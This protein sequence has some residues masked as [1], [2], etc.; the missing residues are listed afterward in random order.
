MAG[1]C[2]QAGKQKRQTNPPPARERTPR[3]KTINV[4]PNMPCGAIPLGRRPS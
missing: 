2:K 4:S 1:T 3:R